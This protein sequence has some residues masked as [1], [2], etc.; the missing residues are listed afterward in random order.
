MTLPEAIAVGLGIGIVCRWVS[1]GIGGVV[2][3]LRSVL[4]SM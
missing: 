1:E 3:V 2:A 4:R